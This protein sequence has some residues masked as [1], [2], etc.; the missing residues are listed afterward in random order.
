MALRSNRVRGVLSFGLV[1]ILMLADAALAQPRPAGPVPPPAPERE[2]LGRGD[3]PTLTVVG[4]GEAFGTP[5]RAVVRLGAVAQSSQAAEAQ[6]LVGEIVTKTID[7]VKQLGID[8]K[9]IRTAGVSLTPVYTDQHLRPLQPGQPQEPQ[10]PRISGYRASNTLEVRLD[11]LSRLGPV[12]DAGVATGANNVE[13]VDFQLKDDGPQRKAALK[14][15]A[16]DARGKAEALADAMGMRLGPVIE[17]IEG[18]GPGRPIP[19]ARRAM[20]AESFAANTP[21]QPGQLQVTAS[22]TI[23]YRLAP[24]DHGHGGAPEKPAP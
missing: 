10:E 8:E 16:T 2:R 11:D 14:Q 21:V 6:K 13:G 24:A 23:T 5:D 4:T 12:I 20:L 17:V 19:M 18:G 7:A 3:E 22:V 9:S 1:G 15:A